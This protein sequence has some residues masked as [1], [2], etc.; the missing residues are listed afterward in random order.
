MNI[1]IIGI[2]A[3][4]MVLVSFTMTGE[5][6]IRSINIIG[7]VLFVIYGIFLQAFSIWFMN[8]LLIIIQVY[9]ITQLRKDEI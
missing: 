9:K 1:E 5:V 2:I 6:E 4:L 8:G 3:T 7:A